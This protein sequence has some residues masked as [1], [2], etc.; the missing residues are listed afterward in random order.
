MNVAAQGKCTIFSILGGAEP[1][2][3]LP[4]KDR[5][6]APKRREVRTQVQASA[7]TPDDRHAEAGAEP[8][9]VRAPALRDPPRPAASAAGLPDV[10]F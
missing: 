10:T 5:S 3:G 6:V 4:S 1:V 2:V 8:A 7:Q 9:R